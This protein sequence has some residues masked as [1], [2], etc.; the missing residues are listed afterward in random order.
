LQ[1]EGALDVEVTVED[2]V[3]QDR[4]LERVLRG[5]DAFALVDLLDFVY[6]QN[7]SVMLISLNILI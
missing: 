3:E 6:A 5:T 7:E 1:H 2:L 4:F